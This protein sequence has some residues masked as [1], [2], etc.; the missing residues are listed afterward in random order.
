[1]TIPLELASASTFPDLIRRLRRCNQNHL[2][3]GKKS[4]DSHA[5]LPSS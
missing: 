1:M 2:F 3:A 5:S 4:D